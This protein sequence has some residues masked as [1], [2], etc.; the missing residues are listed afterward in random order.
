MEKERK[1]K[2]TINKSEA[3]DTGILTGNRKGSFIQNTL[4]SLV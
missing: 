4:L 3:D 1:R 2:I